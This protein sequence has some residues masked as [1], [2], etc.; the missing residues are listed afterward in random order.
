[1]AIPKISG[2]NVCGNFIAEID[3]R[4][5]TFT[6]QSNRTVAQ[7]SCLRLYPRSLYLVIF[8]GNYWIPE[9]SIKALPRDESLL[10]PLHRCF[11]NYRPG[12]EDG[13]PCQWGGNFSTESL[14]HLD[15]R[16]TEK[17]QLYKNNSQVFIIIR[18]LNI[19]ISLFYFATLYADVSATKLQIDYPEDA[20]DHDVRININSSANQ[21]ISTGPSSADL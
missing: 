17:W 18:T 15:I 13:L 9:E 21:L 1:M 3:K 5:L 11:N 4:R 16:L 12:A 10:L 19:I 8:R 20:R 14:Y 7:R 2:C 6:S